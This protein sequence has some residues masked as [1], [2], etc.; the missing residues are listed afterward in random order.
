MSIYL[1]TPR[2]GNYC[3]AT[4]EASSVQRDFAIGV[5]EVHERLNSNN[6]KVLALHTTAKCM[7]A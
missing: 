4:I 2:K 7:G 6:M 1:Y 3:H 5:I